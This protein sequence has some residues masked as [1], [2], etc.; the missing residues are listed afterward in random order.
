MSKDVR[1]SRLSFLLMFCGLAVVV[2]CFAWDLFVPDV[3]DPLRGPVC[4][5]LAATWSWLAYNL[6]PGRMDK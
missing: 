6:H 4:G 5:L 2:L 1:V 3:Y